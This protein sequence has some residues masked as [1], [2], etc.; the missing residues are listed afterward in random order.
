MDDLYK[1]AYD[2]AL[3]TMQ[4]KAQGSFWDKLQTLAGLGLVAKYIIPTGLAV[5]GG[6]LAGHALDK[7]NKRTNPKVS[8]SDDVDDLESV[9]RLKR[10][11]YYKKLILQNAAKHP[12]VA[13]GK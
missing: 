13:E 9:A 5:G 8:D 3:Q 4:K 1:K 6:L 12:A 11:Q 2:L 7:L 10:V